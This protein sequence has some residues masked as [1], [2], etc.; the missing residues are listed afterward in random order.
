MNKSLYE[1]EQVV[2]LTSEMHILMINNNKLVTVTQQY[3]FVLICIIKFAAKSLSYQLNQ[4]KF[5]D[6]Y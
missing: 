6:T 3:K 5:E 4:G 2:N 1:N